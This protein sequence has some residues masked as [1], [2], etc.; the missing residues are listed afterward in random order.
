MTREGTPETSV[1][2]TAVEGAEG[3]STSAE[4]LDE[5]HGRPIRDFIAAFLNGDP[6]F[7]K[8]HRHDVETSRPFTGGDREAYSSG[9]FS[10]NDVQIGGTEA[11]PVVS[12]QLDDVK[13][14]FRGDAAKKVLRPVNYKLRL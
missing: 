12:A 8:K 5:K 1:P 7:A 3:I 4:N 2:Q 10:V 9:S 11:E 14:T 13:I 6:Q